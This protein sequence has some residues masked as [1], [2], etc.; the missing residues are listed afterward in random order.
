MGCVF[1]CAIRTVLM[2]LCLSARIFNLTSLG[3]QVDLE[4]ALN[5]M[6]TLE[7]DFFPTGF[8]VCEV[9]QPLGS[10]CQYGELVLCPSVSESSR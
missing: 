6:K 1:E 9:M 4:E 10:I 7:A 5:L 3:S 2:S 8:S